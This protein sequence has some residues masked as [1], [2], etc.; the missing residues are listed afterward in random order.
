MPFNPTNKILDPEEAR[1]QAGQI[2]SDAIENGDPSKFDEAAKKADRGQ[3]WAFWDRLLGRTSQQTLQ[4]NQQEFDEFM[5]NEYNSPEALKRQYE[6]AGLNTNLLGST[7]FGT[8]SSAAGAPAVNGPASPL[9]NAAQ[10]AQAVGTAASQ[11]SDVPYKGAMSMKELSL[12]PLNRALTS[13]YGNDAK[14]KE[15]DFQF[16]QQS[17]LWRLI[18]SEFTAKT[19]QQTFFQAVQMVENRKQEFQ[20]LVKEGAV[21]DQQAEREKWDAETKKQVCEYYVK[22]HFFPDQNYLDYI[23]NNMTVNGDFTAFNR[24]NRAQG[25]LYDTQNQ[26]A[27]SFGAFGNTVKVG[28]VEVPLSY[29][30]QTGKD[31]GELVDEIRRDKDKSG[32][33]PWQKSDDSTDIKKFKGRENVDNAVSYLSEYSPYGYTE[34]RAFNILHQAGFSYE[35]LRDNIKDILKK[36]DEPL[37]QETP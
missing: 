32:I 1:E 16:A 24:F 19:A 5:Y 12:V 33:W 25:Y 29:I 2:M 9:L 36:L 8:A 28:P 15:I 10:A 31:L 21:L 4:S 13:L 23:Y 27:A 7:S 37:D 20:N 35:F 6:E 34:S 30:I 18:D 26:S 22:N 11:F 3:F 14:I 17:F